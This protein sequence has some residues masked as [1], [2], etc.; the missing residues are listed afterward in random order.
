MCSHLQQSQLNQSFDDSEG[1]AQEPSDLAKDQRQVAYDATRYNAKK[2]AKIKE[3]EEKRLEPPCT[4]NRVPQE[5]R[6]VEL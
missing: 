5:D 1:T 3:V 4:Q 2:E 6:Y